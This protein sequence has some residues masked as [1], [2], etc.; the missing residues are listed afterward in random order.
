MFTLSQTSGFKKDVKRARKR[1]LEMKLL[2]EVIS[3]LV[4]K[5]KLPKRFKPHKLKGRYS[6]FWENWFTNQVIYILRLK[7]LNS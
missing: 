5:G 2:D 1:G 7:P 6:G 3:T 4:T